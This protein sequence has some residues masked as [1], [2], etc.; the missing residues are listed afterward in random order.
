M[1]HTIVKWLSQVSEVI[2]IFITTLLIVKS[3]SS[4]MISQYLSLIHFIEYNS[5]SSFKGKIQQ[6]SQ[7]EMASLTFHFIHS[8]DFFNLLLLIPDCIV[9]VSMLYW[10]L[11][12]WSLMDWS[13][14]IKGMV[15]RCFWH[16][17]HPH[18]HS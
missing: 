18:H 7:K 1:I 15:I 4:G 13:N 10:V 2:S 16:F 6:W 9:F 5:S 17:V 11:V 12:F 3:I 14:L 8:F